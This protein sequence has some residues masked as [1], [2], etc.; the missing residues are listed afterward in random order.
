MKKGTE[1]RR[2][3]VTGAE[4]LPTLDSGEG[5][6]GGVGGVLELEINAAA[7]GF[8]F[9]NCKADLRLVSNSDTMDSFENKE[10]TRKSILLLPLIL[11][12]L[13]PPLPV[14]LI[15]ALLFEN[16]LYKR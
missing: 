6:E 4:L 8:M 1:A 9:I 15:D 5:E 3:A 13:P 11:L 12:L 7:F 16:F 10:Y 14:L 2:L